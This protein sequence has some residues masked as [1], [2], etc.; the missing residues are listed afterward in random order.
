MVDWTFQQ[1]SVLRY[2][3]LIHRL[4][5]P[6]LIEKGQNPH[7]YKEGDAVH[8]QFDVEILENGKWIPYN[9]KDIQLEFVR[10]DPFWRLTLNRTDENSPT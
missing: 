2:S 7:D 4:D 6:K 1:K 5:D 9:N 10:I 8:F 3:N